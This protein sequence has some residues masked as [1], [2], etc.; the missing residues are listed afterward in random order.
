MSMNELNYTSAALEFF[1]AVMTVVMLGGCFLEKKHRPAK[2]LHPSPNERLLLQTA[3]L[4]MQQLRW[5]LFPHQ[6]RIWTN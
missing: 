1:A 6:N 4:T 2:H 3:F 5:N